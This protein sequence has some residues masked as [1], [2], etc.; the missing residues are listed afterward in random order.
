MPNS[1]IH[2]NSST[3]SIIPQNFSIQK[4]EIAINLEDKILFSKD[5]NN[6]V[7]LVKADPL[8]NTGLQDKLNLKADLASP[9][10]TGNASASNVS[11]TGTLQVTSTAQVTNLNADFLDGEHGTFYTTNSTF[12][13]HTS[14]LSNPHVVTTTQ[15]NLQNVTNESK[16]TMF[17]NP[18][19]T[20]PSYEGTLTGNTGVINIGLGQLY[21]AVSGKVG[22]NTENPISILTIKGTLETDAPILGPE[23]LTTGGWTVNSG[24]TGTNPFTHTTGTDTL[25][26]NFVVGVGN[27]YQFVL[28]MTGRNAGGVTLNFGGLTTQL[29]TTSVFKG[30]ILMFLF[31]FDQTSP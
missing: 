12:A 31:S 14:N 13:S 8:Y 30:P 15:L 10:F 7:F 29:Y 21:K 9:T 18:V 23:L 5:G 25:T 24:W 2:K 6:E 1:Y 28:T 17:T 20:N 16:L 19:F 22:I 3:P 4:A 11:I 26:H 27:L